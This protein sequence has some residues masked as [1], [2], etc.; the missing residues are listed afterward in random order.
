MKRTS[1]FGLL[2]AIMM[3]APLVPL[4]GAGTTADQGQ[5][6]QPGLEEAP[7]IYDNVEPHYDINEL[8]DAGAATLETV[9]VKDPAN[10]L[11]SIYGDMSWYKR[12]DRPTRSAWAPKKDENDDFSNATY[13]KNGDKI[14]NNVT[15][16][17]SG[18]TLTPNDMDYFWIN[19]TVDAPNSTI[20]KLVVTIFSEDSV[21]KNAS[22]ATQAYA[23]NFIFQ[24]FQDADY[25]VT[26]K[27]HGNTSTMTFIPDGAPNVRFVYPIVLEFIAWNSTT[28]NYTLQIDITQVST[29]EGNGLFG[30]G[31]HVNNTNRNSIRMKSVNRSHDLFDW[32]DMTDMLLD[33]GFNMDR[34]DEVRFS[35]RV[36]VATEERGRMY[37]YAGPGLYGQRV[38]TSTIM[39][40]YLIWYNYTAQQ[41]SIAT[42]GQGNIPYVGI[43]FGNDPYTLGFQAHAEFVW[44]GCSPLQLWI[45]GTSAFAGAEGN[46]EV[47]YNLTALNAVIIP[48]NGPPQFNLPMQNLVYDE[49]TGPWMNLTDL[50]DHFSDPQTEHDARL[51]YEVV[52][53]V[54]ADPEI[55]FDI[56]PDTHMLSM[57]VTEDNWHSN[58]IMSKFRIRCYDWGPNWIYNDGDDLSVLSNEFSVLIAS[59]NDDAYIEKV[60]LPAGSAVNDHQPIEI[61][62]TQNTPLK[63]KKIHAFDVDGDDIEYEHNATTTAFSINSNGQYNFLPTND[64]VGTTW[65]QVTVDDGHSPSP[66]D[67]VILKFIVTNR[68]DKP[69]LTAI[70]WRD[71]GVVYDNLDVEDEPTFRNVDEDIELNLTVEAYDPDIAIG[72]ADSL[73]W[74]V[75]SP[76]WA[77]YPHPTNPMKAY[78]AYFPT[79]EDAISGIA[80]TTLSCSDSQ[81]AMSQEVRVVLYVDNVN[82]KPS[83]LTINGEVP[84]EGKVNLDST[85]GH[86]GFEDKPYTLSV[87][88]EEIDPRDDVSFTTNDPSWQPTPVLGNE[89]ARNFT[90]IPTQDMVGLHSVRITVKDED[91]AADTV[92]VNYEIVNT[93]DP[94][95][96]PRIKYDE[97][98]IRYPGNNISFWCD[99]VEDQDGDDLLYIWNFGDGT[100]DVVGQRVS[101]SWA[102]DNQYYVKLTV[103][104]PSGAESFEEITFIIVEKPVEIDPDLDTDGD[105]MPDI[106]EEENGLNKLDPN[107]R[108]TD[109]DGDGFTNFQEFEY[110]S[111]PLDIDDHPPE[112][113]DDGGGFSLLWIVLIV[114]IA[115]ILIGAFGFFM[116]VLM[117]KPQPMIQQQMYGAEL[118]GQGYPG[119]LPAQG[120]VPQMPPAQQRQLPPAPQEAE[121]PPEDD[122]LEGF[123]EEAQKQIEE[124]SAQGSEEENVWKPPTES[125]GPSTESQVDDLFGEMP[126][127]EEAPVKPEPSGLKKL[128]DLPPPPKL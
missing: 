98:I 12:N 14:T 45:A 83:I 128:P 89:F 126:A 13:L 105:G 64:E 27:F 112:T 20:D 54:D 117:A 32:Y 121:K 19:L 1:L 84:K 8:V 119:A 61:T 3:L 35:L 107:D 65:I 11:A 92:L 111:D 53:S 52:R 95:E 69:T 50:D 106:Y 18:T 104:D 9:D 77:A 76:G 97:S 101:H 118:P 93:N 34:N 2:I 82:D 127:E 48:P 41:L 87:E 31:M 68:N 6:S 71:R 33:S 116:Y 7:V 43:L 62:I 46:A 96:K 108:V 29:F 122:Y 94:P 23:V 37:G 10:P 70:E 100:G 42:I 120:A 75:G 79:N 115:I 56:D 22:L 36:D 90:I 5:E 28:L 60:D 63:S 30:S 26:G 40:L 57:R 67:Y 38:L 51:R 78:L 17:I 15:S 81:G 86:N 49:D 4:A 123:M 24:Q 44:F 88:A 125:E 73:T 39:F 47:F 85:N 102:S 110:G 21:K 99:D 113:P 124:S 58:S 16:T 91:G 80:E 72:I 25:E 74:N 114:I 55:Q 103:R 59:V 66:D 109:L